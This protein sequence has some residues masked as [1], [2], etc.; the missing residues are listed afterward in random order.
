M[1]LCFVQ[2][3]ISTDAASQRQVELLQQEVL[4]LQQEL[5][6]KLH[7]NSEAESTKCVLVVHTSWAATVVV[8]TP[9]CRLHVTCCT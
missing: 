1:C 9:A 6:V 4:D 3:A 5:Q 7:A 2:V 8:C